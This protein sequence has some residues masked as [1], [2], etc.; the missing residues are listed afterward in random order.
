MDV[1]SCWRLQAGSCGWIGQVN[2]LVLATLFCAP[3]MGAGWGARRRQDAGSPPSNP[4]SDGARELTALQLRKIRRLS[5]TALGRS[6]KV[7]G[8]SLSTCPRLVSD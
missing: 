3:S 1:M 7:L 2:P 4:V 6:Q 5:L 8:F